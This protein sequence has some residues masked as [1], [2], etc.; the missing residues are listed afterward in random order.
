MP[1]FL[2]P[3]VRATDASANALSGAKWHFYASGGL[4]PAAIYT[5]AART[6]EHAN[7]VVADSGGL[8][9]PIYLDPSI[10]YRAIQRKAN[11]DLIQD[12]DPYNEGY[13][14][15]GTGAVTRTFAGKL[16]DQVSVLDFIPVSFHAAIRAKT[17]TTD[18][19]GYVQAGID[20]L[21]G[22]G[23]GLLW[24]P[25]G[26]YTTTST[27]NV[28][29]NITIQGAG[30]KAT[31]FRYTGNGNGFASTWTLNSSTPVDISLR[32]F[33]IVNTAGTVLTTGTPTPIVATNTGHGFYEQGGSYVECYDLWV[34]GFKF[35]I[36]YNQ[37][38]LCEIDRCLIEFQ[39]HSNIWLGNT[40][41]MNLG[42]LGGFTNRISITRCQL[43]SAGSVSM[44]GYNILDDGGYAHAYRDNNFNGAYQY[45]V[46]VAGVTGLIIEG[47]EWEAAIEGCVLITN[48][49]LGAVGAS[50]AV[51][52][53]GSASFRTPYFLC[54]NLK[55]AIMI[56]SCDHVE[57]SGCTFSGTGSAVIAAVQGMNNVN[58][59][60]ES[61]S[62]WD[63]SGLL[64]DTVGDPVSR[65]RSESS[66]AVG[67]A[68]YDPPSLA[69]GAI[70]AETTVT[71]T[72]AALGDFV[73]NISFSLDTQGVELLARVSA[74]NTVAVIPRNP[75][76]GTIDLASGTL[77][78]HVR[79][80][81]F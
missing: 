74:A 7:P 4:V 21:N 81:D 12:I 27:I 35:G 22:K 28:Y 64:F 32:S 37:S 44:G 1:L 54:P 5:T 14:S 31:V 40:N 62:T 47:G 25:E 77:R 20:Y 53:P 67:Q 52:A 33:G 58:K 18:V 6:T 71:V 38:E 69:T 41:A 60:T 19:S 59:L 80:R 24:C 16:A 72:G 17:S 26:Q 51:G 70:G 43:N 65:I 50:E 39:R 11:G 8:F 15:S 76:A 79:R 75:T 23:G 30:R 34:Y 45:H 63:E 49:S 2:P 78:V 68:T 48:S 9:A 57:M 36:T 66:I 42:E 46:R 56:L 61:G 13:L 73:E 29:K 10:I 55:P 3:T